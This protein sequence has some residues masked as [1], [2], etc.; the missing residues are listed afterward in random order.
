M[1]IHWFS[2]GQ[3]FPVSP[4]LSTFGNKTMKNQKCKSKKKGKKKKKNMNVQIPVFFSKK[5]SIFKSVS[6]NLQ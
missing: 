2:S 5:I 3:A 1:T 6:S 4:R